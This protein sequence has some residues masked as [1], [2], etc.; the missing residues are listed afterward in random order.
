MKY[1]FV[2]CVQLTKSIEENTILALW[3]QLFVGPDF[4]ETSFNNTTTNRHT[5]NYC[6][7]TFPPS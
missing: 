2:L 6:G 5:I 3:R 7:Y 4:V 1:S